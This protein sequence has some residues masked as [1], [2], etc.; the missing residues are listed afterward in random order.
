L[1]EK[2]T[3]QVDPWERGTETA[4]NGVWKFAKEEI[5]SN[6]DLWFF[7]VSHAQWFFGQAYESYDYSA[8][9]PREIRIFTEGNKFFMRGLN[10]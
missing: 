9:P 7:D 6:S 4:I 8:N 3:Y 10:V 5:G 1:Q 2:T